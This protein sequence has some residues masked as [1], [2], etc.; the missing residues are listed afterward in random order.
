MKTNGL[1]DLTGKTAVVIGAGSGI[2]E[3]I[4]L[5]F[6]QHGARVVKLDIKPDS[7]RE[8][9]ALDV[10]DTAAVDRAFGDVE[11]EHGVDIAVCMPAVNVR[12]PILKYSDEEL[13][14]VLDVNIKGNFRVL[15]A[16]GR[17]MTARRMAPVLWPRSGKLWIAEA[18]DG[19]E[20]PRARV[21]R[22]RD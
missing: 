13:S 18:W 3:A 11:R 7:S 9:G 14:F 21:G 20:A 8:I 5:G 15:R 1:F 12:K 17:V 6:A 10:C 4:A 22:R 16:A 2:G 19:N